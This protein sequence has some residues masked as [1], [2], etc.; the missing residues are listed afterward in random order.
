MSSS[1]FEA[2]QAFRSAAKEEYGQHDYIVAKENFWHYRVLMNP[3]L[4]LRKMWFPQ[5]LAM[6]LRTFWNDFK[7]GKRPLGVG[8]IGKQELLRTSSSAGWLFGI[9][10]NWTHRG[11]VQVG[12]AW[13]RRLLLWH[14]ART[15]DTHRVSRR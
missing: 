11:V 7:A 5:S 6:K 8:D 13:M 4:T 10:D 12:A 15:S 3:R 1:Q 14:N 9:I 2:A